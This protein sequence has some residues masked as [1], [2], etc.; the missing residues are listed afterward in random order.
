VSG[1][2]VPPPNHTQTPNIY[3]DEIMP[4]IDTL[5]EMKVT[6]AI[7]RQTFGWHKTEDR[8]SL[9]QLQELTGLSRQ[10][11]AEGVKSALKRG[12]IGRRKE[13]QGYVYGLRV[14]SQDTRPPDDAT[15]QDTRPVTSQASRHTKER[16]KESNY[17][18][19]ASKAKPSEPTVIPLDKYTTDRMYTAFKE[20]GFPRWTKDEYGFHLSRVQQILKEDAP[21]DAEIAELPKQFLD[22]FTNWNPKADAVSTL[23]EMRRH[24]A[25]APLRAIQ[26][27]RQPSEQMVS[28]AGY[29]EFS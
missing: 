29:R 13:G 15:S 14:A 22:Y 18:A 24:A 11:V 1:K 23:R 4:Q 20:A 6:E 8:L 28:T 19:N 12:Y 5:A 7:I 27:G 21:T 2:S 9:S 3:Y 25:R 17:E 26:G 16:V 10:S